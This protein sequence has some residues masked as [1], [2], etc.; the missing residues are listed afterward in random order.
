MN[1]YV[2]H[3]HNKYV[4]LF[5]ISLPLIY[6]G[7]PILA[8]SI[9]APTITSSTDDVGHSAYGVLVYNVDAITPP[10]CSAPGD[11]NPSIQVDLGFAYLVTGFTFTS[12]NNITSFKLDTSMDVS[13]WTSYTDHI[14]TTVVSMTYLL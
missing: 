2:Y 1:E 9:V 6:A 5:R 11:A 12:Q 7:L 13:T 14:L 4:Q 3:L 8:R 10:W